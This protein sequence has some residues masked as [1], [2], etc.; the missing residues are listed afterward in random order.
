MKFKPHNGVL[1]LPLLPAGRK[2]VPIVRCCVRNMTLSFVIFVIFYAAV[3][4]VVF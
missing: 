3:I 1:G 4:F 2:T